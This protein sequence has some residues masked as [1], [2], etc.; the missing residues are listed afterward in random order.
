MHEGDDAR[1]GIGVGSGGREGTVDH[2]TGGVAGHIHQEVEPIDIL[3][4]RKVT[5]YHHDDLR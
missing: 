5:I 3:W 4:D 1:E 2:S